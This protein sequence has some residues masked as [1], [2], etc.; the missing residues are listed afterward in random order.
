MRAHL[1][2]LYE[3]LAGRR[4]PHARDVV[5]QRGG[6]GGG[7]SYKLNLQGARKEF[8]SQRVRW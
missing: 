2:F 5:L 1:K 3:L 7:A 4:S 8:R 6:Y